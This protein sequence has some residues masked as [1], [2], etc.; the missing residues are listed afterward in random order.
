LSPT[1]TPTPEPTPEP[2]LAWGP[3]QEEFEK[4][5]AIVADMSVEQQAGQVIVAR[6]DETTAP[7]ELV[8][9]LHLGGVILMGH[10]VESPEQVAAVTSALED[11]NE[12]P[13]P[14]VIS[15][16]QEGGRVARIRQPA[17]EFPSLM[18][19]GASRDADLTSQ[20]TQASGEE[21]RSLGFTMVFAPDADVTTGPD[22][23]TIGS[24]SAS[25]DPALVSEIVTA[26]LRGYDAAGI[27]AVAKHFPGHGSVPADSH[28]ELPVQTATSAEL[29]DRDFAPFRAAVDAGVP[30]M[31]VAHIDVESIDPGVPSSLSPK[32]IGVLRDEIGFDGVVI[33]DALDM[34]AITKGH[35]SGDAAVRALGAGADVL[36]MPLDTD[37]AHAGVVEAVND[38][39]LDADR[40]AEAA[41]RVVAL[42]LHQ[43]DAAGAPSVDVVGSNGATSYE[44]SLAGMTVVSGP[45]EGPLVGQAI[46]IVGG[47]ETDRDR[48]AAAARDAGLTVGSGDVVRL[49]GAA[50]PVPGNGDVVVSLDTPYALGESSATTARIAL[51]NRTPQ[52]FAALVDVLT[53]EA[54]SRGTLPVDVAGVD[55]DGCA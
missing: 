13:Y 46:Q 24:R 49:L 44:A 35:N 40:L 45:C 43:A 29:S 37:A 9:R 8:E 4:A 38:G 47:N 39:R 41:T 53:G 25:S 19:L 17:T 34:A 22:D 50:P 27:L 48:L 52:A 30:A 5:A 28:E 1:P 31:M 21:L 16:D 2:P 20:V 7:I 55:R 18:T 10:N 23:P 36:L 51:Y 15:V 11:A 54:Q 12:R 14:L 42:M 33:T 6:Y 26:A 3:T 32:V